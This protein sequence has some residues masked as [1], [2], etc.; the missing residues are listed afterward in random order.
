MAFVYAC[1]K[2]L[3]IPF[4]LGMLSFVVSQVLLRIPLL[5]YL[6]KN[7][8]SYLMF[9]ATQPVLYAIVVGGLTAGIFEE[10]A[11][12]L[13]MRYFLKMK[14][15]NSGFLF[16]LGHGGIEAIL[17]VGISA[18]PLIFSPTAIAYNET[19]F[20][21]GIERFFAIILHM[22]LSVIVLKGV[23][24]KRI[25]YV[26]LAILLHSFINSIIGILPLFVPRG[27]VLIVLESTI[28]IF[29]IVVFCFSL[30]LNR[31]GD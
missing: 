20:I 23:V 30:L 19:Y 17:F 14:E 29:A 18:V 27:I 22:G 9:S 31:R 16:G 6:E 21:S 4:V 2:K 12:F 3:H 7:S 11:R 28:A 13:A 10:M 25:F 1:Y 26:L 24:T 15:W 5:E 8:T